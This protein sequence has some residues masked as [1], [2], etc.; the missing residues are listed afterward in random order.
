[1]TSALLKRFLQVRAD[2]EKFCAPLEIEDYGLQAMPETSPPK[3]HLAHTSWFYETFILKI[4]QP[5]YRSFSPD[6]E[7]LFNSYYNGIGAQHPRAERGLLSRPSLG[8]VM[9]YRNHVT[10]AIAELL[11]ADSH[12]EKDRTEQL[13]ELGTHHEQQH[14]ELFFTDIK[15]GF[16]RN[17]LL[18]IYCQDALANSPNT[19]PLNWIEHAGGEVTV[20]HR[21][22]GFCFDNEQP[23][24]P[25]ILQPFRLADRLVSNGE[26]AEF[27]ADGGYQRPELWLADGWSKLDEQGWTAPLYWHQQDGERFEYTLHGSLPLNPGAPVSHVSAYEADAYARWANARLPSEFEWEALAANQELSGQFVEGGQF[28]PL[29][30]TDANDTQLYGNLWQWTSSAYGPYPGYQPA[31]GAVGEYNGKFMANQLVLRGGSC[32]TSQ[33][34]LRRSYRNFFYPPDRWQFSGI[35]LAQWT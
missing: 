25:V 14:Q 10:Q 5:G 21:A 17:P 1:M 20:G 9:D 16:S 13:V 27:I 29:A 15:Y 7:V 32:V 33:S 12:L 31:A 22:A 11:E 30:P 8:E 2:S 24:H 26:Y 3:W 4:H 6:F 19:R 28:H 34:Q 23:S 18:P 35:R